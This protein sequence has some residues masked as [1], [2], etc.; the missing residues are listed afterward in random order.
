[1]AALLERDRARPSRRQD[2]RRAKQEGA[3]VV[4]QDGWHRVLEITTPEAAGGER[5]IAQRFV[6]QRP[7]PTPWGDRLV[8]LGAYVEDGRFAGYFARAEK[9]ACNWSWAVVRSEATATTSA[10]R[11]A[12]RFALSC[13]LMVDVAA[14]ASAT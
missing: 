4:Y 7:V 9:A 2:S 14:V 8:T 13:K 1:M 12:L 6:C 11:T 10:S 3:T 5:W